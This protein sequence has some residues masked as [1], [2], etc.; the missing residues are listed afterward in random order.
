MALPH[1]TPQGLSRAL[2]PACVLACTLLALVVLVGS[3]PWSKAK[4]SGRYFEARVESSRSGLVQVYYD[5]GR[6]LNE[7]DSSSLPVTAGKPATLRF[8]LP[9]G[10]ISRLRFDPL[11]AECRVTVSG[12]QI[13]GPFG[14]VIRA[15]SPADFSPRFEIASIEQKGGSVVIMSNP[16]A[17]DPSVNIA[18]NEPVVIGCAPVPAQFLG[19]LGISLAAAIV[20]SLAWDSRALRLPELA[21]SLWAKAFASPV[22]SAALVSLVS[23]V[24]ANYPVLILGKSFVSPSM[25]IPVLYGQSPWLPSAPSAEVGN[26]NRSD[27]GA[28]VW[29]HLP[30][31][32]IERKAIFEDGELPLW[33]RY[34]SAG[35][36]LLGQ[37]QS[38]FGDP[39]QL[40]PVLGDGSAWSWDI[41]FLVAKWLFALGIGL[42]VWRLFR[43]LPTAL[44]LTASSSFIGFFVYRINHPAIFSLTYAPWILYAW[45]RCVEAE[46]ARAAIFAFVG[47]V[48]AN[49]CEMNS[50]T[51][52]EAYSLLVSMNLAG[53]CLLVFSERTARTKIALLAGSLAAG[54]VFAMVSAP[55]W[56]TFYR[57]LRIAYTSYNA[58]Q[59]FQLQP[60]MLVGLFDEAFYRPFQEVWGVVNPS[61]NFLVLVGFLWAIVRIRSLCA[62]RRA[63]GL[64]A[65]SLPAFAIVFGIVPP[66]LIERTPFL[67][68]ILHVD[69]AFSCHHPHGAVWLRDPR[70][71]PAP[72]IR[73]GP[74]GRGEG[75]L[76]GGWVVRDLLWNGAGGGEGRVF[77]RYV[78]WLDKPGRLHLRLRSE[79]H[80]GRRLAPR[81][82]T[83]RA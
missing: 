43:H 78:G 66:G 75:P 55:V 17:T 39:L 67:G 68:N 32:M 57:A 27:V 49:W 33:N 76:P 46:S 38:C 31:S 51:A 13:V 22:R 26:P 34:D 62:D 50:G 80:S 70:G 61:V 58:P 82:G 83:F 5:V 24:L 77:G 3:Q 69:N 8:E 2:S 60:G 35:V 19:V 9:Y 44:V 7:A 65:A 56:Y 81:I 1:R 72:G 11:D 73:R 42:C 63:L 52:K 16:G 15:F 23:T 47:L 41:K 54:A 36:P 18:L 48:G 53:A 14:G 28:V 12:A 21:A 20:L 40:L 4:G 30:L 64:L 79:P 45:I 59:A 10:S 71:I 74:G 29:H 37:G 25:G 6:E